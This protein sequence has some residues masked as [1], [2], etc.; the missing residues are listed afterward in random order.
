MSTTPA[1][2]D[3]LEKLTPME[4]FLEKNFKKIVLACVAA[5]ALVVFYG[6]ARYMGKVKDAEAAAA[7]AAA[8]TIEDYD[9]VLAERSGT[10]AAGNALLA[11]AD[12][13]WQDNKKDSSIDA[14]NTFLSKHA[15]HP[16]KAQAQL[17]FASKL[18]SI[19]K[20]TEA[21]A[22]FEKVIA[23]NPGSDI[24]AVAQLRLGDLLWAEGKEDEARAVYE[25]LPAKFSNAS[26]NILDQGETRLKWIAAKLP[27][28]EVDGP[29]K[30][31]EEPK[32]EPGPPQINLNSSTLL[33]PGASGTSMPAI[34]LTPSATPKSATTPPVQA[35]ADKPAAPAAP[36]AESKPAAPAAP[37]PKTTEEAPSAPK[38]EDKPADPAAPKAE[39]KQAEPAAPKAP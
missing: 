17:G 29:P 34:N 12:L 19:G 22:A 9:I 20:K 21:K 37:A 8:K 11:K 5:I 26:E 30:P 35:P 1:Q 36:K 6:V 25:S 10:R 2:P 16:L 38:A 24:A 28:T 27:T 3:S 23:D 14:L 39:N 32:P 7:F 4:E 13:L 31:K 18:D 33:T 15:S